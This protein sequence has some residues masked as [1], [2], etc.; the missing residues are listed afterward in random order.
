MSSSRVS[1]GDGIGQEIYPVH[2]PAQPEL[3][4]AGRSVLSSIGKI[5]VSE[6][7]G[8]RGRTL[9]PP[10]LV[11]HKRVSFQHITRAIL[12]TIFLARGPYVGLRAHPALLY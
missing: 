4:V 12:G 10:A 8:R 3:T 2:S 7:S 11:N 1:S 9:V 6:T 5:P